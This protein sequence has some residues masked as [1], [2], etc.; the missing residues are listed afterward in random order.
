MVFVPSMFFWSNP[1]PASIILRWVLLSPGFPSGLPAENL[2][3]IILGGLESS[4]ISFLNEMQT[5]LTPSCSMFLAI[6]PT[7]WLQRTH[8]GVKKAMSTPF[9]LSI[10]PSFFE[11]F[12]SSPVL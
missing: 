3:E 6:T 4:V 10:L 11:F 5:V 12:I 1:N 7:D 2:V 9:S 8:V